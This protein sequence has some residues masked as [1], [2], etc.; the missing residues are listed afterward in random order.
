MVARWGLSRSRA[1]VLSIRAW[2][3]TG[4]DSMGGRAR[5]GEVE[6]KNNGW[7]RESHSNEGTKEKL[8]GELQSEF[9]VI[10]VETFCDV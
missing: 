6:E 9:V 5:E 4:M 10:F 8:F 2:R 3:V 7:R 1:S